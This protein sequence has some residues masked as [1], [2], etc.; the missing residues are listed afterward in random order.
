[1]TTTL[2]P[3]GKFFWFHPYYSNVRLIRDIDKPW[4]RDNGG[5]ICPE[6]FLK[7]WPGSCLFVLGLPPQKGYIRV[8]F[9]NPALP[10]EVLEDLFYWVSPGILVDMAMQPSA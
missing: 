5:S 3:A 6:A 10:K 8:A 1:M 2:I 9:H 4:N 7:R